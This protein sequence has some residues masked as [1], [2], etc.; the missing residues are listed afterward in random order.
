LQIEGWQKVVGAFMLIIKG[1][2]EEGLL[3]LNE[4]YS[5]LK[6]EKESKR[7]LKIKRDSSQGKQNK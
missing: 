6:S 5:E 3:N 7:L 4:I 1:C 2:F